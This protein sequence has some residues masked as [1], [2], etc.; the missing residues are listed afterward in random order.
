MLTIEEI[1]TETKKASELTK[2]EKRKMRKFITGILIFSIGYYIGKKN[3]KIE[4]YDDMI[5]SCDVWCS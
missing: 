2:E 5:S 4:A 1:K 3:G